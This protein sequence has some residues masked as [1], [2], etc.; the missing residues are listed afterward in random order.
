MRPELKQPPLRV[1]LMDLLLIQLSNF[2]WSWRSMVVTGTLTPVLIVASFGAVAGRDSVSLSYVLCGSIVLSLMFQNQNNVA[3][4]FA[5]MKEM[6]TLDFFAT[7]PLH[8]SV[9]I[10]ATVLSFFLLSIPALVVTAVAGILL[11]GVNVDASPYAAVV[12]PL[13]VLPLAGIGALIG[14]L[15]RST[16][17][18]GS[19]SL[20]V[21][22]VL[23]FCGPVMLPPDRLPDW[24]MTI[25]FVSPTTYGA[26][27]IRQVLV[28][29]V[30]DKLWIDA[31]V[32]VLVSFLTLW[33]AG[34]K[35]PW[36]ER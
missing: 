28:G 33:L 2:R 36:R 21:T 12:I 4:N 6:G 19:A 27:A 26:S 24:I 34:H 18:A 11:L 13:C 10:V 23:L 35:L 9:V 16:E 31:G 17:E 7:L 3:N 5:Y 29:P 32:L 22:L 30:T 1:Q 14:I 25:S 8:R 20:L 15:A